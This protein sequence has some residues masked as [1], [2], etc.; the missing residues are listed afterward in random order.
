M[1]KEIAVFLM[2]AT[3]IIE[4]RGAVP[5]GIFSGLKPLNVL[6]LSILGSLL[7]VFPILLGLEFFT[8]KLRKLPAFDRFFEWLFA[9][10]RARTKMIEEFETVGLALFVAIPFPGTGVW[11]G[12]IAAYLLGIRKRWA[13][14][15][16]AVGTSIASGVLLLGSLGVIRFF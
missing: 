10:T 8:E 14:L 6:L 7:P 1:A 9:R 13:F 5:F 16:A 12:C 4:V 11:T 3:P 2:A 15:A